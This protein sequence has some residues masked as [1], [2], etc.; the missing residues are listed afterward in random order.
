MWDHPHVDGESSIL[1]AR[2]LGMDASRVSPQSVL[3]ITTLSGRCDWHCGH[4]SLQWM[5]GRASSFPCGYCSP[6]RGGGL[7]PSYWSRSH[8]ALLPLNACSV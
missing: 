4:Q 3:A 1:G 7:L 5:L 8:E 2:A 6:V